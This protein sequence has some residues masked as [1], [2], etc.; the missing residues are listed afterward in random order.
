M[1]NYG[2]WTWWALCFAPN[3]SKIL[4]PD[5]AKDFLFYLF[6]FLFLLVGSIG[7]LFSILFIY[8]FQ[9]C[10]SELIFFMGLFVGDSSKGTIYWRDY[11]ALSNVYIFT[12]YL[13]FLKLNHLLLQLL[14]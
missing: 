10:Y 1:R 3:E 6:S 11:N 14:P 9:T 12:I 4:P 7:H 2:A 8:L 5:L 13:L